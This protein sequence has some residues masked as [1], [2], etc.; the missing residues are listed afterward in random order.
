MPPIRQPV[1]LDSFFYPWPKRPPKGFSTGKYYAQL[2]QIQKPPFLFLNRVSQSR[3][4]TMKFAAVRAK[5]RFATAITSHNVTCYLG[6]HLFLKQRDSWKGPGMEC[7][8]NGV[9]LAITV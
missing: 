7:T 6:S 2:Q 1:V 5:S 8:F 9:P 4:K 3:C